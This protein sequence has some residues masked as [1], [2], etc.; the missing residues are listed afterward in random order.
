MI[1]PDLS[2]DLLLTAAGHLKSE[3]DVY[4]FAQTMTTISN[5]LIPHLY[6]VDAKRP[7]STALFWTAAYR[8]DRL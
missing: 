3:A 8:G 1:L 7:Q 2:D 6:R 5:L 4:A